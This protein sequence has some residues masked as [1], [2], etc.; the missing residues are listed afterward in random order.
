M[1]EI[2][3]PN[4][5]QPLELPP[6]NEALRERDVAL[7][8]RSENRAYHFW[9]ASGGGHGERLRHW[10]QAECEILK[11]S[12]QDQAERSSSAKPAKPHSSPAPNEA[13]SN[14]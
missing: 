4:N 7:R 10:L 13:N 2:S 9:L 3:N 5:K 14:E 8:E 12:R 1:K 6:D 11:A